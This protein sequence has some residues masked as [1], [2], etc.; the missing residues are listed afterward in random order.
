MKRDGSPRMIRLTPG[1]AVPE[2]MG[3][4][5]EYCKPTRHTKQAI[6][7]GGLLMVDYHPPYLQLR[8]RD[9]DRVVGEARRRG[10]RVYRGK[11]H[12]TVTDGTYRARIYLDP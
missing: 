2:Y 8:C 1:L 9:V 12:I 10:L 4:L 7:S 5:L 3:F 6:E 11:R